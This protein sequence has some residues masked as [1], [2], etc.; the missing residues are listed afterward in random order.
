MEKNIVVILL[1]LLIIAGCDKGIGK[2]IEGDSFTEYS[3]E[4]IDY[5]DTIS[6]WNK[7]MNKYLSDSLWT[8]RDIYDAGHNLMVPIHAAFKTENEEWLS[9][10]DAHFKSFV[11]TYNQENEISLLNKL[12][13]YYA[14]SRYLALLV[15]HKKSIEAHHLQIAELLEK[16]I[17]ANWTTDS[18]WH[19]DHN[20]FIGM[21]DRLDYKLNLRVP[22]F[23]YDRA[24]IDEELFLIAVGSDLKYFFESQSK[25][26]SVLEEVNRYGQMIFIQEGKLLDDGGWLFQENVWKDH[27]DYGYS[28][29]NTLEE[30]KINHRKV[31][32]TLNTD[33]SHGT[34]FPLQV[35]SVMKATTD[36]RTKQ[37]LNQIRE[38]LEYQF[39]EK[40]L[41]KKND[42]F[43]LN[44]FMD[45]SNGVYR[46][47]YETNKGTGYGPHSLSGILMIGWYNFLNTDRISM[48]YKEMSQQFP[49]DDEIYS[50]YYLDKT[51]RV[52]NPLAKEPDAYYKGLYQL[53]LLLSSEPLL[54][55]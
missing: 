5:M 10:I 17:I 6:L 31:R 8:E 40:I 37:Q 51:D 38:S 16:E 15:D 49:I 22:R 4:S 29:Y 2:E 45:G 26:N 12:H 48:V 55:E 9:D 7:V 50:K 21:K 32:E 52:R 28:G 44:N 11:T 54:E 19:W 25:K 47:N 39:Y 34:R 33:S 13:Y 23:S 35:Y 43:I 27:R 41:M 46:Y 20:D 42:I 36:E 30:I 53:I 14:A 24:I 3:D 18:A 1:T